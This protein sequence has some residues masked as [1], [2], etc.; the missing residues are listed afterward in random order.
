M[1]LRKIAMTISRHAMLARGDRV[2][3]AVSGG[4]DS[5]ALLAAL[6]TLAP[7]HGWSLHAAH[8]NH[9]ARGAESERDQQMVAETVR[10]FGLPLTIGAPQ[11]PLSGANFEARARH[12]RYAF[13]R[14]AAEAAGCNRIATGHTLDDQAET[15]LLRILRGSGVDGLAAIAP[16]RTD[17]V[18]RPLIEC[19]RDE[20]LV[21]LEQEGVPYVHDSSNDDPRYLRNRVR[22]ELMPLLR[23]LSPNVPRNLARL[24]QAARDDAAFLAKATAAVWA[25]VEHNDGTL[26]LDELRRLSRALQTRVLRRWLEQQRGSLEGLTSRHWRA[27]LRVIGAARPNAQI[28]LPD[29]G[30]F[31]R[32]YDVVRFRRKT[33]TAEWSEVELRAGERLVLVG[34]WSFHA[35]QHEGAACKLPADL[36]HFAADADLLPAV[37]VCRRARAGDRIRPLG[38]RGHRKLQDLFVDRRVPRSQRW[39]RPVL[40]AG[41]ELLWVPGVARSAVA[42]VSEA[43]RRTLQITA[44]PP[45]GASAA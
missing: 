6:A 27:A 45:A 22:L 21:F 7:Q 5:T 28:Q 12:E 34:G 17:G 1:I 24:S 44:S 25:S 19:R 9:R 4:P 18:V 43:T 33:S 3:L 8:F 40:T 38:M 32:A 37:L 15:V 20:L 2:L 36:F 13:L 29:G 10:R 30:V 26:H 42:P 16:V 23:R 14:A 39:N 35:W 11:A 41:E 31:E